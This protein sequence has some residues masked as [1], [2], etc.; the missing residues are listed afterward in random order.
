MKV[1]NRIMVSSAML[2]VLS[3]V[4]MLVVAGIFLYVSTMD[5]DGGKEMLDPRIFQAEEQLNSFD[6]SANE[7]DQ[8]G[9]RLAGYGYELLVMQNNGIVYNSLT[10]PKAEMINSL[11]NIK[12]SNDG[13]AGRLQAATFV[14][15]SSD[16]Y[17]LY[18]VKAEAEDGAGSNL[19]SILQPA[20][21]VL[22]AVIV[23]IVLLSQ[24]FTRKMAYR[25]LLPL[26]AL[27]EGAERVKSG[28][29]SRPVLYMG[30]DEFAAV[31]AAFNHMQEHLLEERQKNAAYEKARIDLV[32]GIS[33]DLRT[34]L[35]S[36]KGYIKGLRDG[37]AGTPEKREQYLQ[38]AYRKSSEMDKLLQKLFDFSSLETGNLPLLLAEGD[39]GAF[40]RDYADSAREELEHSRIALTLE[41]AP[42]SHPVR[43]DTEQMNRVM[44]N[45]TDNAIKYAEAS[46]L[47]LRISVWQENGREHLL[48]ADNGMGVPEEQL[49]H[50]FEQF[51]RGDQAR[52]QLKGD[53][54]GLGLYIV[55]Y[56]VERHGGT[57]TVRNDKGLQ[58]E[59]VLPSGLENND[60]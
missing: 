33:H 40:V 52:T 7:W 42:G 45:L 37:V 39:L 19:A 29:L 21:L 8:L 17:S 60:A 11:T 28:D 9:E 31:C 23:V 20:I 56:I 6:P 54:S 5:G 18:A 10:H 25:I 26:N 13:I 38:I 16:G 22:V 55:K 1:I 48:F 34:P 59:L 4:S 50:L 32:A 49:P 53:S 27:T 46:P 14:A 12:L 44:A 51:W 30:K 24:L 3:L 57:V 58:I 15:M 36:I 41:L 47:Q 35:T 43:I 2:V